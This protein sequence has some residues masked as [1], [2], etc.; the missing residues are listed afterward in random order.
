[1]S[2]W[3]KKHWSHSV[4]DRFKF[5]NLGDVIDKY[6]NLFSVVNFIDFNLD[7]GLTRILSFEYIITF[8]IL[9]KI[10][11]FQKL[12]QSSGLVIAW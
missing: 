12:P 2:N 8:H 1:M 6:N 9:H 7:V 4:R 3:R 11:G 10:F 5:F